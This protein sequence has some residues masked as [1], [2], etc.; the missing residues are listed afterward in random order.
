MHDW[1]YYAA[2]VPRDVAD[3]VFLEAMAVLGI[4]LWR[5]YL[6]YWG[7]RLGG[8]YAWN[9]HKKRGS[10]VGKFQDNEY[11]GKNRSCFSRFSVVISRGPQ[12]ISLHSKS[13][14]AQYPV[15]RQVSTVAWGLGRRFLFMRL[16]PA[17]H[18]IAS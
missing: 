6:I 4:S 11:R 17:I 1:L 10:T 8:W 15:T 3:G 14:A 5:R 9:D 16:T 18:V 13:N 7:V 2:L 12:G